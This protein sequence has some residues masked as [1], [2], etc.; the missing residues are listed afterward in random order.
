M[1][2][3]AP[4]VKRCFNYV[5]RCFK[6]GIVVADF[7]ARYLICRPVVR[8]SILMKKMSGPHHYDYQLDE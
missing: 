2:S 7:V 1:S 4:Y 6:V 5:K 3:T 8:N